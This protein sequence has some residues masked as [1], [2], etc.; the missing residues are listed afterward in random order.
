MRWN[1]ARG[2][3]VLLLLVVRPALADDVVHL[4]LTPT[5]IQDVALEER[6]AWV[7]LTP[8]ASEALKTLTQE[9]QGGWLAIAIEGKS[10]M[11]ILI[12]TTV[13]SGIVQIS[14]P[15]PELRERLQA[16]DA[17]ASAPK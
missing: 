17:A 1:L 5:D 2:L 11:K 15:S 12:Q 7:K 6:T 3:V 4:N 8:A 14:R 13:D 16:I 9:N 10:A